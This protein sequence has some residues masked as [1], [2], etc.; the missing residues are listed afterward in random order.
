VVRDEKTGA[1]ERMTLAALLA[2]APYVPAKTAYEMIAIIEGAINSETTSPLARSALV[3]ALQLCRRLDRADLDR[4]NL[5][6]P[7]DLLQSADDGREVGTRDL[8]LFGLLPC[9]DGPALLSRTLEFASRLPRMRRE[10]ALVLLG[11]VEGGWGDTF[12]LR[13]PING[14]RP[15]A[16]MLERVGGPG[17]VPE[18]IRAIKDVADWWP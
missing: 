12:G 14:Q 9:L 6:R 7:L 5:Q 10:G 13:P 11:L 3:A 17:A 4:L 16:R 8:V 15:A 2:E 18:T 1:D